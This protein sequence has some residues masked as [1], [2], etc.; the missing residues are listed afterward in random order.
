MKTKLIIGATWYEYASMKLSDFQ[1]TFIKS[2]QK[3]SISTSRITA[4]KQQNKHHYSRHHVGI[5]SAKRA[6]R[7]NIELS[8]LNF[9]RE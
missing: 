8:H 7:F 1:I 4:H 6:R 2:T 5:G 3:N 9:V